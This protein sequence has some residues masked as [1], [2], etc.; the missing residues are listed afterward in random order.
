M[1]EAGVNV[2]YVV[3]HACT[4]AGAIDRVPKLTTVTVPVAVVD[5]LPMY[6]QGILSVLS[7]AGYSVECPADVLSWAQR[8][9][10]TLVLLTL[11]SEHTWSILRRLRDMG[12]EHFV[13]ALVERNASAL[14]AAA[15]QSGARSVLWRD[16]TTA[17]LRR[18]VEAT[19]DG[20]AVLPAAVAQVLAAGSAQT[21]VAGVPLPEQVSWLRH[22]AAGS[23]VARLAA[24]VGYSERAM[25]RLLRLL[26]QQ[27]GVN[28]RT[29]A[30]IRA[31]E[32]GWLVPAPAA[33]Y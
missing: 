17:A 12:R 27:M 18:T 15:V 5:P 21:G 7:P 1:T 8:A 9:Q 29:E 30:I 6:R 33:G 32:L 31:Q 20:Q 19:I 4:A 14:G 13:V 28:N 3:A 11:S 2:T 10:R 23:T 22:L 16:V 25:F 26:Y 24:D